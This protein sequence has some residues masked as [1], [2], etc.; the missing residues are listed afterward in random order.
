MGLFLM[1]TITVN[2]QTSEYEQPL[3]WSYLTPNNTL[4]SL[5]LNR[6]GSF[7]RVYTLTQQRS[8]LLSVEGPGHFRVWTSFDYPSEVET[9]VHTYQL[10]VYIDG[11]LQERFDNQT[12]LD[13]EGYYMTEGGQ[14]GIG[15]FPSEL[16]LNAITIPLG[17]HTVEVRF[18]GRSTQ[19]VKSMFAFAPRPKQEPPPVIPRRGS[20]PENKPIRA[21]FVEKLRLEIGSA[22]HYDDNVL[23]LDEND[24]DR[25]VD[26]QPASRWRDLSSANDVIIKPYLQ[27][28][29][30][31]PD[32]HLYRLKLS[33]GGHLHAMNW[34]LNQFYARAHFDWYLND[35]STISL[36]DTGIFSHRVRNLLNNTQ[37][38]EAKAWQN[39]MTLF[40]TYQ[41]PQQMFIRVSAGNV[42]K[43]YKEPFDN[44]SYM[45]Y[46]V[47]TTLMS[48]PLWWNTQIL[49]HGQYRLA[50][51]ASQDD[52]IDVGYQGFDGGGGFQWRWGDEQDY[53]LLIDYTYTNLTFDSNIET[54]YLHYERTDQ[55][56]QAEVNLHYP[57]T[58]NFEINAMYRFIDNTADTLP[59]PANQL[60]PGDITS[61]QQQYIGVHVLYRFM[62][63]ED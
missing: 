13:R 5:F 45:E 11:R 63:Q 25:F 3:E 21:T 48:L 41:F 42:M 60:H 58:R 56:H 27:I 15:L 62:P 54:D 52:F 22:A 23:Q 47:G 12:R 55:S 2:G 34:A 40:Y 10:A 59:L 7:F 61:Y 31:N 53:S 32:V 9:G 37:Y 24:L 29:L 20:T 1:L 30:G 19:S 43:T 17:R 51:P 36:S 44:R 28:Q 35:R 49:L 39:E 33:G 14:T 26:N 8:A 18:E 46:R 38:K 4:E 50:S 16:N 57:L 6:E